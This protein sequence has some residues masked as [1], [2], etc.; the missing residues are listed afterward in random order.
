[1]AVWKGS[2]DLDRTFSARGC[3]WRQ[4]WEAGG[5]A[6]GSGSGRPFGPDKAGGTGEVVYNVAVVHC[7]MLGQRR[8]RPVRRV[9]EKVP[10]SSD[11]SP[12]LLKQI[13][14]LL[15][16]GLVATVRP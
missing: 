15:E 11:R 13:R 4:S 10:P 12:L 16:G 9:N 5:V 14:Q 3:S 7:N 8:Q 2:A 1:M 6:G